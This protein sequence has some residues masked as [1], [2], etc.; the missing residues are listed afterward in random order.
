[1]CVF[2]KLRKLAALVFKELRGR[3]MLAFHQQFINIFFERRRVEHGANVND[4]AILSNRFEMLQFGS[5]GAEIWGP[6]VFRFGDLKI[7]GYKDRG[8][9]GLPRGG[10]LVLCRVGL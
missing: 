7:V 6:G 10:A 5:N 4:Q 8:I 2:K 9:G 3:P 1:L